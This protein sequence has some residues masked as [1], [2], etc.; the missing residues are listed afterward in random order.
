M[1]IG[2][3]DTETMR[4][5]RAVQEYVLQKVGAHP[6]PVPRRVLLSE[7]QTDATNPFNR[8]SLHHDLMTILCSLEST[9]AILVGPTGL[10]LSAANL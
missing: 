9:D 2:V 1:V 3:E 6:T 7:I 4:D 8:R 5:M 10:E